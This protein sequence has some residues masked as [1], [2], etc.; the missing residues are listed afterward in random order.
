MIQNLNIIDS[1]EY[2][3]DFD[4]SRIWCKSIG[5]T[6]ETT[7]LLLHGGPGA[8]S[9]YLNSLTPLSNKFNV[10]FFDQLGCG[11]SPAEIDTKKINIDYFVSQVDLVINSVKKDKV[12]LYG[13]SWGAL[14]A[15]EYYNKFPDKV[16][17]LILSSPLISTKKWIDDANKLI[18]TLPSLMQEI[19]RKSIE[20][21][22]FNTTD[23]QNVVN[24]F[25]EN[26][27][28]RKLPW[29]EDISR[30][31]AEFGSEIYNYMWGPC[32]F[33]SNGY[34]Q[35]YDRTDLLEIINIPTLFICGEYDEILPETIS[36]YN[37]LVKNSVLS[38]NSGSAH[39]TMQDNPESD[40]QAILNF[41]ENY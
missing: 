14:L 2:F 17:K 34:L 3:L 27:V 4:N 18:K 25:Y 9:Y 37:S 15:L 33:I 38:I 13:Q 32:E 16:E 29:S 5:S 19:I 10:V 7:I 23:Y 26:F 36:H 21:Q 1:N 41:L 30:T 28:A 8:P 22:N 6:K 24:H 40:I 12:V 31:F 35:K 39:L 11:K 20:T